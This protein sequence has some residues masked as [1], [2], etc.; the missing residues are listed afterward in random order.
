MLTDGKETSVAFP[1]PRLRPLVHLIKVIL[2]R[3]DNEALEKGTGGQKLTF[4]DR[5]LF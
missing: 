5:N 3:I 1:D 2:V 4:S